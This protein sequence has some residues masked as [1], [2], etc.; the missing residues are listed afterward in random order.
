MKAAKRT[1]RH[2]ARW[3]LLAAVMILAMI[4]LLSQKLELT[5]YEL[6]SDRIP[7]GETIRLA[8]LADLHNREYGEDNEALADWIAELQPDLILMAGDMFSKN[9][10][11]TGTVLSLCRKLTETAPVFFGLG[12]HEGTLL[13]DR[14]IPLDTLLQEAGVTVLV[15]TSQTIWIRQTPIAVGSVA[16]SREIY[17]TYAKAFVEQFEQEKTFRL[18]IAHMPSLFYEKM[19]DTHLDLAVSGHYHGGILQIPGIG[20]VFSLDDGLFPRYCQGMFQLENSKLIVSRGMGDS[21]PVPRIHNPPELILVDI[22]GEETEDS[23][24]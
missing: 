22:R 12:N 7:A 10:S 6:T 18:M 16:V 13:Y 5:V 14:G 8:V 11:D 21:H 1:G 4:P 24:F 3:M 17:D 20:G 9:S 2:P 19:A 15:N 23:N